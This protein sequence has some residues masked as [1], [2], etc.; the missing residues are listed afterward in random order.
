MSLP[1][2]VLYTGGI[3]VYNISLAAIGQEVVR[4]TVV[5]CPLPEQ[6]H[7]NGLMAIS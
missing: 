6:L 1:L 4:K 3:I 7:T 2:A 5:G